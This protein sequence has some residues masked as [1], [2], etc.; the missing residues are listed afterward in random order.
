MNDT[1]W[2]KVFTMQDSRDQHRWWS[3]A[4]SAQCSSDRATDI[5]VWFALHDVSRMNK[6][7]IFQDDYQRIE[8]YIRKQKL[9]VVFRNINYITEIVE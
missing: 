9:K 8:L 6:A 3:I 4:L 1:R 7:E 2:L 5:V